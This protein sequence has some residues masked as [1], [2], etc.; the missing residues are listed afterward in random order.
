MR[1]R[2]RI[3]VLA[4]LTAGAFACMACSTTGE[5]GGPSKT[6]IG[7]VGGAVAGGLLGEVIGGH[8]GDIAAGAVAGGL[9]G[10]LAGNVLDQRDRQIANE[11]AQRSLETAPTG[12]PSAWS[13]PD[14]GNS[15]TV[16]PTRTYQQP[17]GTYCREFTQEIVVGG[18][19]Q[20]AYG[21]A[22]RQ[23]DGTWKVVS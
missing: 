5:G 21:T 16:T 10:A 7:A 2:F 18:E 12:S 1:N 19:R 17:D 8:G 9:L 20:Q 4:S 15:G 13:N 11:A 14:T 23:A 22:C 3:R 6:A